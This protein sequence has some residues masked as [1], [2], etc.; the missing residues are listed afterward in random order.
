MNVLSHSDAQ[1]LKRF[2]VFCVFFYLGFSAQTRDLLMS[3]YS[4][5]KKVSLA[6]LIQAIFMLGYEFC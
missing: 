3:L 2:N 1:I 5:F 4:V 6:A